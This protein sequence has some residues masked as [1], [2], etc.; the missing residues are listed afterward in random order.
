MVNP[1]VTLTLIPTL[2]TASVLPNSTASYVPAI[3]K[4]SLVPSGSITASPSASSSFSK[5]WGKNY[6][7]SAPVSLPTYTSGNLTT[8]SRVTL[9]I[10]GTSTGSKTVTYVVG[11][12]SG[13]LCAG[14]RRLMWASASDYSCWQLGSDN[15]YG[16]NVYSSSGS[17]YFDRDG[18]YP[19]ELC[20]HS[21]GFRRGRALCC[22]SC[23]LHIS[24][25]EN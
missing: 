25:E 18:L 12:F 19:G 21:R 23:G 3:S 8:T 4:S 2:A 1:L 7:T 5:T 15:W 13:S 20:E 6:T 10:K 11:K 9:T 14:E 16:R 24:L 22:W 17:S